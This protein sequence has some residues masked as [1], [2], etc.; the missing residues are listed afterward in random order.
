M[1]PNINYNFAYG[2]SYG[3][4]SGAGGADPTNDPNAHYGWASQWS[5]PA[6][7]AS[8][9]T[10][11]FQFPQ[12][13][14][15]HQ[16]QQQQQAQQ[17]AQN[18]YAALNPISTFMQQQQKPF[19]QQQQQQQQKKFGQSQGAS[20]PKPAI[21]QQQRSF[22]AF[23]PTPP[24]GGALGA[25][26]V[27]PMSQQ[28]MMG[29]PIPAG[30][31]TY[32]SKN[33]GGAFGNKPNWRQNKQI[34]PVGPKKF[35]TAGKTPAMILHEVFKSVQEEYTEV[36]GATPK[37]YRC[38]LSIDGRS[39]QMESANKKAAKQKC[40]ELAVRE[41]RPDLHVTPFEEGVT[42]KAVPVKKEIEVVAGNGQANKRN[43]IQAAEMSTQSTLQKKSSSAAKKAKLFQLSPVES[44]LSLLDLMQKIIGE[45]K[46]E[47]F[48]PIFEANELPRTEEEIKEEMVE[49]EIK[50]EPL[51]PSESEN[52]LKTP[53]K[54]KKWP[55]KPEILNKCTLKFDE[56][57]K[58]YTKIGANRGMLKDMVIR[59]ALRDLFG[60]SQEDITTVA[61]RHAA[62][63]LG[64]EMNIVQC[65]YTICSVLNCTVKLE[66]E[67]AEDKPIGVGR[68]EY[69]ARCIVTDHNDDGHTFETKTTTLNSKACAKDVAASEML[70]SYFKID[71]NIRENEG[72]NSQGPCS[73]LHAMLNK[74]TKQK[75]KIIYD[76]KDNMPPVAGQPAT[77]FY[78]SCTIDDKDPF[79]GSGRSKKLAKNA[80]AIMALQK[81]FNIDYDPKV[82]YPLALSNRAM[83]ESKVSPMC[84]TIAE[85]CKREY[86]QMLQLF[87]VSP[88]NQIACFVLVNDKEEKRL[89][90]L[91]ASIN[92]V[93]EPD[94]LN[95]ANGTCLVHMDPIV[96]AR[97]ALL[98]VLIAELATLSNPEADP[99]GCIFEKRPDGR[100]ALKPH[101]KLMLYSNF[102]PHCGFSVD[103][104][105]VKSLAL[106][107]QCGPLPVPADTL[108]I[109][110]IREKKELRIHC[111]ADKIFKWNH[112]G[113]QGALLSNIIHPIF[114]TDIF[115]GSGSP[116]PDESL[117][118]AMFNRLK[119]T[120]S[121]EAFER[122]INL[123]SIPTGIRAMVSSSQIWQR[124]IHGIEVLDQ[125]TARTSNGS[126][127]KVCK[128]SLF[129]AYC[130]LDGV[131]T[132]IVNYAK[133]K[134]MSSEYQYEKRVFYGKVEAAGLGKWQ[135]KPAE[136]ID[137]FT[138]AAFD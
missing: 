85:F 27:Q 2:D 3:S 100:A 41:L 61:R 65:L 79:T 134:E 9:A 8:Q 73:I 29:G 31:R 133:A 106:I 95:G 15:Q 52:A 90:S 108:T 25:E 93:V 71:P 128:A 64:T 131:D 39:F 63:R 42:A 72:Q 35:D 68:M 87:P 122:D 98:K 50:Q 115:F 38:T 130:K 60:V 111:I 56:Q 88:N 102:S 118:F 49:E 46:D 80:A 132:S 36:E 57:G 54:A 17:Q 16:Q 119:S 30:L 86:H 18:A 82:M 89:L 44:A 40:A 58:E 83:A 48:N 116:V 113:V 10:S 94:T 101:F 14:S 53:E 7:A 55:K 97:R 51:D 66:C 32:P 104:A 92:L 78:C 123:E 67:P 23:N 34:K 117:K 138:L 5:Q 77:V 62:K 109:E 43:K 105:A 114:I 11:N 21:P 76:F 137:S 110:E 1:D 121:E 129:E 12:Y 126:P 75:S 26:W 124:G 22:G 69:M 37:R 112:L 81:L 135:T 99:S 47:K 4:S 20:F 70:K 127:S 103:D 59:E 28:N 74:Q 107:R 13:V 33:S 24:T 6:S 136:L 120:P 84:R 45:S 125:T 96:L 91:A 19:G